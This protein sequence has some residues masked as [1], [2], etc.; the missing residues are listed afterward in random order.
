MIQVRDEK[1]KDDPMQIQESVTEISPTQIQKSVTDISPTKNEVRQGEK[2]TTDGPKPGERLVIVDT[3][4]NHPSSCLYIFTSCNTNRK[5]AETEEVVRNGGR[6]R[7]WE[8]RS[9]SLFS[10]QNSSKSLPP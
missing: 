3:L 7:D 8:K 1:V 4:D 5:P 9:T 2:I 10:F 6:K